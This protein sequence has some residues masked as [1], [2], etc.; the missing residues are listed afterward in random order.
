[1]TT[2]PITLCLERVTDYLQFERLCCALLSDADYQRIEPLG[3]TGDD[4]RDA[5]LR[6]D[7][8]GNVVAF[9]FT[10]RKDWFQKL[11]SD[12]SRIAE[13]QP[14]VSK[15]VYACTSHL[16]ASDKDKA[17]KYIQETYGWHLDLYDLERLRVL[18]VNRAHLIAHHP[19]IF[20]PRYFPSTPPNFA[21]EYLRQYAPLFAALD[22][23][24]ENLAV[25][26]EKGFYNT[27]SFFVDASN[28]AE[29]ACHDRETLTALKVLHST[30]KKVWKVISDEHYIP[31][32]WR[33]KF[34]NTERSTVN[35]QAILRSKKE[36]I[37]PL[38]D[39]MRTALHA[40]VEL[41]RH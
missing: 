11:K 26:I 15:L 12:G 35:V 18:L 3:G 14:R 40:F 31:A 28:Q 41:A 1:M 37:V 33:Q 30:I 16:S 22:K 36:E 10:V 32:G 38:L 8:E 29:L 17:F 2:D 7:G 6:D 25:E 20:D 4:G 24:D 39:D 19:G 21:Q 13:T 27:L 9:A 5:I 23:S 34:D